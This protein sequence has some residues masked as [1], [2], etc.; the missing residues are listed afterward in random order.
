[1]VAEVLQ[2]IAGRENEPAGQV[3]QNVKMLGQMPARQLLAIMNVGYGRS[4]GVTCAHCHVV[5]EWASE[6]KPQKQIAR[7]MAR[8]AATINGQLLEQIPNLRSPNPTV[9]CTTCHRGAVRPALNL[10]P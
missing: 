3:F 1:M 8:M 6:E 10:P 5:G 2:R 9:N 4:L 7:E